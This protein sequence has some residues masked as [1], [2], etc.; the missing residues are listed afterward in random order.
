MTFATFAGISNVR[1]S[2]LGCCLDV[3]M[4]VVAPI[5]GPN[6]DDAQITMSSGSDSH[7]FISKPV[8][9][10]NYLSHLDI[11]QV[12]NNI[13]QTSIGCT[14]GLLNYKENKF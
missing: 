8:S 14:L 2:C 10:L 3:M 13:R 11:D 12:A 7:A 5:I 1:F 6:D 4:S 9:H